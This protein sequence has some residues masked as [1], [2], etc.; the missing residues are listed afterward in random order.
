MEVAAT[1]AVFAAAGSADR[2]DNVFGA[3]GGCA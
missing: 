2:A 1:K 3:I